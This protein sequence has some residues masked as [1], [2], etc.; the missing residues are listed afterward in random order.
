MLF[1][2]VSTDS[3]VTEA[4]VALVVD[5]PEVVQEDL[6]CSLGTMA[7]HTPTHKYIRA[8]FLFYAAYLIFPLVN[9]LAKGSVL[10]FSLRQPYPR[11]AD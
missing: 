4:E 7:Q 6:L 8:N 5:I 11:G 3:T 2:I 9:R 1:S 10:V